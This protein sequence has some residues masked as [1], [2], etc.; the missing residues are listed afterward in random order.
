MRGSKQT[1]KTGSRCD[2]IS[3]EPTALFAAQPGAEYPMNG[4][5]AEKDK[6][7][8]ERWPI[9]SVPMGHVQQEEEE[10]ATRWGGFK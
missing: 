4:Q 1:E 6:W 3:E 5:W 2:L 9:V 10:G 8:M 7:E